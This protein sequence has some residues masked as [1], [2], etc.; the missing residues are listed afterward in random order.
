MEIRG[1]RRRRRSCKHRWARDLA[2]EVI[3][4]DLCRAYACLAGPGT[5]SSVDPGT[6][7]WWSTREYN[8]ARGKA[9][10]P[11]GMGHGRPQKNA[12]PDRSSSDQQR[13]RN[14][15]VPDMGAGYQSGQHIYASQVR[16]GRHRSSRQLLFRAREKVSGSYLHAAIAVEPKWIIVLY[17]NGQ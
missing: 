6:V 14:R 8:S 16:L 4:A 9:I 7:V 11:P 15:T 13:R 17:G 2:A 5:P 3:N 1:D 10:S 12:A